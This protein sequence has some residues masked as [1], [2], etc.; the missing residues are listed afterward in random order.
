MK[1]KLLPMKREAPS[2]EEEEAGIVRPFSLGM[3]STFLGSGVR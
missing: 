1:A 2:A 3:L